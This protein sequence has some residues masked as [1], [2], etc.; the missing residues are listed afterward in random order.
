[1]I[2]FELYLSMIHQHFHVVT[3]LQDCAGGDI[4][5][6]QG[7]SSVRTRCLGGQLV[8]G[9]TMCPGGGGIWSR[10]DSWSSGNSTQLA[11]AHPDWEKGF[12][13]GNGDRAR[14]EGCFL[15]PFMHWRTAV[16]NQ[17]VSEAEPRDSHAVCNLPALYPA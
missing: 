9:P 4:L 8:L 1:V 6:S 17:G 14:Q 13:A 15:N 3:L 10:G 7:T 11:T 5:S 12:P 2:V 16:A